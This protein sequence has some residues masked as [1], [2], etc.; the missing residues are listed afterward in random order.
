MSAPE[1]NIHLRIHALGSE[2]TLALLNA[3]QKRRAAIDHKNE[4][5]LLYEPHNLAARDSW[6][7]EVTEIT[8]HRPT[9]VPVAPLEYDA[10][11][12]T[13]TVQLT[14]TDPDPGDGQRWNKVTGPS[15]VT[16]SQSGLMTIDPPNNNN[17]GRYNVRARVR[18]TAGFDTSDPDYDPNSFDILEISINILR[19]NIRPT[20]EAIDPVNVR[21]NRQVRINLVATDP[22]DT[23]TYTKNDRVGLIEANVFTWTPSQPQTKTITFRATDSGGLYHERSV[24]ITVTA[25]PAQE[26]LPILDPIGNRSRIGAGRVSIRL[27]ARDPNGLEI[28]FL[29]GT[30]T[31]TFGDVTRQQD[32]KY[33]VLWT[34]GNLSIGTHKVTFTAQAIG[35]DPANETA[36]EPIRIIVSSRPRPVLQRIGDQTIQATKTLTFRASASAGTDTIAYSMTNKH[37]HIP[38]NALNTSTGAFSWTPTSGQTGDKGV[39]INATSPGGT[40]SETINIAVTAPPVA[41]ASPPEWARTP[42]KSYTRIA[43]LAGG[44]AGIPIHATDPDNLPI[45]YTVTGDRSNIIPH[46]HENIDAQVNC[47]IPAH[48]QTANFTIRATA[49]GGNPANEYV[50]FSFSITT[51]EPDYRPNIN[52]TSPINGSTINILASS[53]RGIVISATKYDGTKIPTQDLTVTQSRAFTWPNTPAWGSRRGLSSPYFEG[54]YWN[55]YATPGSLTLTASY[56]DTV[57]NRA[58]TKSTSITVTIT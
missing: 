23:I 9:A 8:N 21:T 45:T 35:G 54:A 16:V 32:G 46:P 58:Y 5:S 36:S 33:T 48:G 19:V 39:T 30:N 24:T 14:R 41:E 26:S 49:K 53:V 44:V 57:N 28:R 31:G 56:T 7:F 50:E 11:S 55:Y 47:T 52:I 2:R 38:N 29:D 25:P 12:A 13:R 42:N 27:R 6:N 20:L 40:A 43:A 51:E 4:L 34:S 3:E 18:D 17:A 1:E 10:N 37:A 22:G 15:W